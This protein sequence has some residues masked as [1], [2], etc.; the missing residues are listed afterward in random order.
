MNKI[1]KWTKRIL[2]SIPVLVVLTMALQVWG[3]PDYRDGES[4]VEYSP[5]GR[6]RLDRIYPKK[7][8]NVRVFST[9]KDKQVIAIVP[10]PLGYEGD[11]NTL[12]IC[13]DD[14]S[15]CYEHYIQTSNGYPV[16]LPPSWWRRIHAWL[17]IKFKDLEDPQLKIARISTEYPP[18]TKK[19]S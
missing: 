1:K 17:T 4:Y 15:E 2:I 3:V 18:V 8:R 14:N 12:W 16:S 6:Y 10:L 5:D 7:G 9:I 13:T 11:I 19:T